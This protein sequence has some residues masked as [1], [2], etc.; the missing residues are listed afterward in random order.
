M[1]EYLIPT[2]G[3]EAELIEKKSRFLGHIFRIASEAEALS[4]IKEMRDRYWDAQPQRLRLP[5]EERPRPLL[6]RRGARE[7]PPGC[8]CWTRCKRAACTT[9]AAW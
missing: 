2:G 5:A 4:H 7:A 3:G 8:R 9:C 1:D 6:R